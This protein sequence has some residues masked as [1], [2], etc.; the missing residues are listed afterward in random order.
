MDNRVLNIK[1]GLLIVV[2]LVVFFLGQLWLNE[3]RV[4]R[5]GYIA[6]VFFNDV[7]GLKLGDPVRVFGIKK[8][9][10][11]KMEMVSGGVIVSLWIERDIVLKEDVKVSIQDVAMISGTKTIVLDP[12]RSDKVWDL[13][14]VIEGAQHMGMSTL[15]IGTLASQFQELVGVIKTGISEGKLTLVEAE[16][17]LKGVNSILNENRGNIRRLMGSSSNVADTLQNTLKKLNKTLTGLNEILEKVN[18]KEGSLGK[19]IHDD[20]LYNELL[21]LTREVKM[22]IKDFRE[23]PKKYINIKIL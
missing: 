7:S 11:V 15:E 19:L 16:R 22:T 14:K 17:A 13:N 5:S 23:N 2:V 10:V 12:G 8:G 4:A 20:A 9:K 1:V 6:K 3:F 21:D 18:K